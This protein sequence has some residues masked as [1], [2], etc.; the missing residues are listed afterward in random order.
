MNVN[1]VKKMREALKTVHNVLSKAHCD[2][3]PIPTDELVN[4]LTVIEDALNTPLRNCDIGTKW[5][6]DFYCYFKP[7][8]G[9]REMP[10]EWVDCIMAYCMWLVAPVKDK[11][12]IDEFDS[13]A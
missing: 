4:A 7:P 5:L 8:K 2:T 6:E 1:P 9:M 10:P 3:Q 11:E 12:V 13:E